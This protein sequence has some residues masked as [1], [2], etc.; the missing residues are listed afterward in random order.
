MNILDKLT[1]IDFHQ[2][3]GGYDNVY[4][5]WNFVYG[6][7]KIPLE[8]RT[9]L[10]LDNSR[11]LTID[12]LLG[13][14]STPLDKADLPLITAA[15]FRCG[16]DDFQLARKKEA[17]VKINILRQLKLT[18]F[19]DI[20]GDDGNIE[21]QWHFGFD[22][23][24]TTIHC[25]TTL[26]PDGHRTTPFSWRFIGLASDSERDMIRKELI[27]GGFDK[28]RVNMKLDTPG[29]IKG[30]IYIQ[31]SDV[32][33]KLCDGSG[34]RIMFHKTVPCDCVLADAK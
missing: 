8:Y 1:L 15:L 6:P 9:E 11:V 17:N 5:S 19:N 25:R 23:K 33:C 20:Y 13:H 7:Q 26:K 24:I 32:D 30:P 4:E 29:F 27:G 31:Q 3:P 22:A 12:P 2:V 21:E 34:E 14:A 16:F 18:Q 10:F 28:F